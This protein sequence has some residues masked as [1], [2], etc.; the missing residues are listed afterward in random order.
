MAKELQPNAMGG[1]IPGTKAAT[2]RWLGTANTYLSRTSSWLSD[3]ENFTG[4]LTALYG[5]FAARQEMK[6]NIMQANIEA[7]YAK[8]DELINQA[9]A[10]REQSKHAMNVN[11]EIAYRHTKTIRTLHE[12]SNLAGKANFNPTPDG[13]GFSR[14]ENDRKLKEMYQKHLF[15]SGNTQRINDLI[16]FKRREEKLRERERALDE[17]EKV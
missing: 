15:V 14:I 12:I 10:I 13:R 7:E 2:Q 5:M 17:R 16:G 3:N 11:Q 1:K 9:K 6:A 8:R 4:G